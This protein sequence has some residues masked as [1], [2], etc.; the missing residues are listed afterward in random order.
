MIKRVIRAIVIIIIGLS[1][2]FII[3][4]P[5][6][7]NFNNAVFEGGSKTITAKPEIRK[8]IHDVNLKDYNNENHPYIKRRNYLLYSVYDVKVNDTKI[9][10][11][12]GVLQLY[13]LLNE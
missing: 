5:D 3:L 1:V 10:H 12:L 6:R 9:Y 11:I 7:G 13:M 4:N 2:L 8:N